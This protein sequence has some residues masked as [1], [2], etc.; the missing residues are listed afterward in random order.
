MAKAGKG[1][2]LPEEAVEPHLCEV[3]GMNPAELRT[4]DYDTI[5]THVAWQ[6]GIAVARFA[7]GEKDS[8]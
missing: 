3:L 8:G 2:P 4:L 5:E 6:E 7:A 1:F